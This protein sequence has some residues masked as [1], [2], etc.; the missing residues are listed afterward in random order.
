MGKKGKPEFRVNGDVRAAE[1][2]V[3]DEEGQMQGIMSSSDALKMAEDKG[4][5]LIEIAPT[6]KPPTCR[7]MDYGNW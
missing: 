7:I 1:V 4:L 3:I 2:R 6:A 5:D